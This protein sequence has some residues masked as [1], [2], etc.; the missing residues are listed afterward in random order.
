MRDQ[1][2]DFFRGLALFFIFIDHV[3]NNLYSSFTLHA[4]AFFDAAEIFVFI[5]G[6]TVALVF[7]RTFLDGDVVFGTAQILRRCWT[8]YV[9]HVFLLV[10]FIAEVS[11][12]TQRF[13]NA[14]FA[15]EMGVSHFLD[16]PHLTLIEGL[17]LRFQPE[18]MDI[19]PLYIVLLLGFIPFALLCRFSLRGAL[20][21]S[22]LIYVAVP[23]LGLSLRTYPEGDWF[24]N[25][26]AWQLLFNIGAAIALASLGKETLLPQRP[27]WLWLAVGFVILTVLVKLSWLLSTFHVPVRPLLVGIIAPLTDKTD[28][29]LLRLLQFVAVAYIVARLVP[30]DAGWLGSL[31]VRPIVLCGQNSLHIFCLGIILAFLGHLFLV[32]IA[33]SLLA[34]TFVILAGAAI[35]CGVA[36][37]MTWFKQRS[38]P[39][40]DRRAAKPTLQ[41]AGS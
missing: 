10:G 24:F 37:V 21:L 23:V 15:E 4:A 22:L 3:P 16:E 35:M 41:G 36:G 20:L 30:P 33:G 13:K 6:Y 1:R 40:P 9:A 26:F 7:G 32:E 19:L 2:L 31:S 14:M 5:S 11:W 18:F 12:T 8:L 39:R 17:L 38:T 25:P 29:D 27:V 34:Q 28:L